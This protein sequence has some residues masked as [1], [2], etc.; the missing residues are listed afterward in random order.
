MNKTKIEKFLQ[1]RYFLSVFIV[2][3]YFYY[4]SWIYADAYYLDF[5]PLFISAVLILIFNRWLY[6]IL[7]LLNVIVLLAQFNYVIGSCLEKF[8]TNTF[9]ESYYWLIDMSAFHWS[10][11]FWILQICLIVYLIVIETK[12]YKNKNSLV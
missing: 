3:L 8:P 9:R 10:F 4:K 7:I 11:I 5:L 6:R 2:L 1:F 12:I